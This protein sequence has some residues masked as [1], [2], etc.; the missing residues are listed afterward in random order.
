MAKPRDYEEAIQRLDWG[1]LRSL[2]DSI[3][4]RET[5][6]WEDGKALEYLVLRTFQLDG[7]RVRWPYRVEID[8]EGETVEQIDGAVHWG[9]LSCLLRH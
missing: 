7:A 6:G 1:G 4:R 5:P 8:P 9:S 3:G 2:W